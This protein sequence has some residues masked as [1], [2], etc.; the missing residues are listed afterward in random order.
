MEYVVEL[1]NSRGNK[2]AGYKMLHNI[3]DHNCGPDWG[4][5]I[6]KMSQNVAKSMAYMINQL[7]GDFHQGGCL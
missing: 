7:A 6:L 1:D 2:V 3:E 5:I 4:S